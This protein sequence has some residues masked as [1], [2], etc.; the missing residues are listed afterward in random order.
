MTCM[1]KKSYAEL[2]ATGLEYK[3]RF[4]N[5]Q[6]AVDSLFYALEL[7]EK[8]STAKDS[9]LS[10]TQSKFVDCENILEDCKEYNI[11]LLEVNEK[12]I[13]EKKL[14]GSVALVL[15]IILAIL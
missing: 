10:I 5:S 9:S 15:I 4:K 12:H 6:M 13:K 14:G 7:S 8:S 2:I 3:L 1:S 11:E